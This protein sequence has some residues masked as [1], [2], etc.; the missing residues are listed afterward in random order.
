MNNM[1]NLVPDDPQMEM[2]AVGIVDHVIRQVGRESDILPVIIPPGR[3]DMSS[4]SLGPKRGSTPAKKKGFENLSR[5]HRRFPR[6]SKETFS[7]GLRPYT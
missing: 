4:L 2:E 7:R 5:R 3:R 6:W 1:G